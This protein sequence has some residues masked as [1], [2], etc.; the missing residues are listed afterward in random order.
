MTVTSL[1][2]EFG[3]VVPKELVRDVLEPQVAQVLP[4]IHQMVTRTAKPLIELMEVLVEV[5]RPMKAV[6]LW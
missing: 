1:G 2:V 5:R 3:R 6:E 4:A